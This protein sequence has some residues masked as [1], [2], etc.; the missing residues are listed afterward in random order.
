MM[1][2]G[3]RNIR[4]RMATSIAKECG[5]SCEF[6]NI[7]MRMM[8][9]RIRTVWREGG[10]DEPPI[11]QLEAAIRSRE[12]WGKALDVLHKRI[13]SREISDNMLLRIVV[14]L[15]KSAAYFNDRD[16]CC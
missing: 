3:A 16:R 12:I 5:K 6:Q 11:K 9:I 2:N 4:L 10:L 7:R 13:A 1:K 8:M 14:S 15:S